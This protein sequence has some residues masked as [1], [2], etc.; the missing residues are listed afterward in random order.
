[1]GR[2]TG[3]RGGTVPREH[4]LLALRTVA[5]CESSFEWDEHVA[6][7]RRA[8]ISGIEIA[9]LAS[10]DVPGPWSP[11]DAALI[12]A[13]DDLTA[14]RTIA[15]STWARLADAYGDAELAEIPFVVGQY[16]M[17]SMVANALR[18]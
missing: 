7:A 1:M 4:E 18:L 13:A 6:F 5:R 10:L 11:T 3:S 12:Q 8:G 9:A 14:G 2:R 16:T 15:Q 17:P